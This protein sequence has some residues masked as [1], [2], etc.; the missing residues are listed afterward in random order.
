MTLGSDHYLVNAKILC[1]YGK[2]NANESRE[3]ITDYTSDSIQ[4]PL[5][6]IDNVKDESTSFFYIRRDWMRNLE[7]VILKVQKNVTNI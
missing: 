7:H 4:L 6:N 5:Y 1:P 3:I 2:N